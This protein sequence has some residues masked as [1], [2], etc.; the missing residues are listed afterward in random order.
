MWSYFHQTE[1]FI[2]LQVNNELVNLPITLE[3]GKISVYK[4]GWYAV[5]TTDFGL[6]VSFNWDS[7][8]FV[9]LPSNYMGAVCGLCGNYN[10][11]PEDDLIP[12]NGKTPVSP[13][14]FG[15]S[16][17]V[18]EIPGCVEGCK[19]VCPDCD[20]NQKVQY[21]K[22]DFCGVVKDAKGPF[23]DCH[24]K[25][26]PANFFEDCVYD[27]CLYKGRKDVLCKAIT[28]YTS[29]CQAAGANVYNWRTVHFCGEKCF[30]FIDNFH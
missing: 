25:V 19:G 18:A 3:E 4:S 7:A 22:D 10:G 16:W 30:H 1:C 20:I 23:R 17:R 13:V 5:V 12:K 27:V 8:V 15:T 29:A 24:A 11:K 26:D 6:K 2:W 21:E 14:D 28:A 9:T